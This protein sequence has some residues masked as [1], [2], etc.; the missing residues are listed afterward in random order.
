MGYPPNNIGSNECETGLRF[1]KTELKVN[2]VSIW[3]NVPQNVGPSEKT[4]YIDCG[5]RGVIL[6]IF[7]VWK[8]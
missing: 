5:K 7:E 4:A 8:S 3:Q 6:P 2:K 1:S